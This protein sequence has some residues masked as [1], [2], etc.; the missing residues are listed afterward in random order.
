MSPLLGHTVEVR[1]RDPEAV[2]SGELRQHDGDGAYLYF[3]WAE[4]AGLH[5]YPKHRIVEIID[6]GRNP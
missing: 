1:L 3:G 6:Q 4:T 2:I 5:F